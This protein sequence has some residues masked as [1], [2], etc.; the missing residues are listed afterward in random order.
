FKTIN[1][2]PQV[3]FYD[4]NCRL[5][6]YLKAHNNPI[7]EESGLLVDVFHWKLKHKQTDVEC[8]VHC[9]P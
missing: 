1:M 8:T 7:A 3:I 2:L 9:N 4:N 6:R 5:Y